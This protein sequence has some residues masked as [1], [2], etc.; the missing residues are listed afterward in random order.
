MKLVMRLIRLK[1][2]QPMILI[3][4]GENLRPVRHAS[5]TTHVPV[6][7]NQYRT[8]D[9]HPGE[10]SLPQGALGV[11]RSYNGQVMIKADQLNLLRLSR[12]TGIIKKVEEGWAGIVVEPPLMLVAEV[13][14]LDVAC[15]SAAQMDLQ[16]TLKLEGALRPMGWLILH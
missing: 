11:R 4:N 8:T 13:E 7:M 1:R 15:L 14:D 16:G 2:S 9:G 6:V 12:L 5:C 3:V 10:M